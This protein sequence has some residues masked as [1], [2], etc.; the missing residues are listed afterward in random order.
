[1]GFSRRRPGK[2]GKPRYTAYYRDLRGR[3]VSVGTFARKGPDSEDAPIHLASAR[4]LAA[5]FAVPGLKI[6]SRSFL[7]GPVGPCGAS[8]WTS[9]ALCR[10]GVAESCTC[11][12]LAARRSFVRA[13]PW[14]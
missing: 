9:P 11:R 13:H 7:R 6:A 10:V 1:M 14:M 3:E 4:Q 8:I 5:A 2:D 12:V